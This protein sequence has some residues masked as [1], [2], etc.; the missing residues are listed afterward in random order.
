MIIKILRHARGTGFQGVVGPEAT[1]QQAEA[2]LQ[3]SDR[4]TRHRRN[5]MVD[6]VA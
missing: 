5:R 2:K 3:M 6:D 1:G 4:C